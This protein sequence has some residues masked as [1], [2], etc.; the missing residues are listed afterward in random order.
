MR[1]ARFSPYRF[2]AGADKAGPEHDQA[3]DGPSPALRL[4]IERP[5]ATTGPFVAV[6]AA[7]AIASVLSCDNVSATAGALTAG[8]LTARS[9]RRKVV[10]KQL[11]RAEQ[12]GDQDGCNQ[13]MHSVV[14]L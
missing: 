8:S 14:P 7:A 9:Q 5:M 13:T 3:Q 4:P 10:A 2:V 12:T 11:R 1:W 6:N